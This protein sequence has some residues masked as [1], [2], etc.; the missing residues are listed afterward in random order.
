VVMKHFVPARL[1]LVTTKGAT[2]PPVIVYPPQGARVDLESGEG[3]LKPLVL[4]LEGGK[5]PFHWV[6]NGRLVPGF[7]RR[8][9]SAWSPDSPGFSTLTVIDALGRSARVSL[10]VE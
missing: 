7:A 10:F 5:A 1:D 2:P 8:R 9:Q 4:K 3:G 6:A